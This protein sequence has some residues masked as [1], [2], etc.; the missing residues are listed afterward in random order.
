MCVFV[1]SICAMC[2]QPDSSQMVPVVF[3]LH[4]DLGVFKLRVHAKMQYRFVIFRL[5]KIN[6][7]E[8]KFLVTVCKNLYFKGE[9]GTRDSWSC[10]LGHSVFLSDVLLPR[11]SPV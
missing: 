6:W 2:K 7:L 1:C 11:P 10:D 5:L 3:F 8:C 4:T 9:T